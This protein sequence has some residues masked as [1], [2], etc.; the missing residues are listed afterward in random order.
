M[1]QILS[2]AAVVTGALRANIQDTHMGGRSPNLISLAL[3][4]LLPPPENGDI[5]EPGVTNNGDLHE[6][7]VTKSLITLLMSPKFV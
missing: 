6:P 3:Y 2:S 7:G 4:H 5:H 1:S